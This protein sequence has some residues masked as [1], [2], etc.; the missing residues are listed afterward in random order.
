M[1]QHESIDSVPPPVPPMAPLQHAQPAPQKLAS[2][3]VSGGHDAHP[4]VFLGLTLGQAALML[5][6]PVILA[7]AAYAFHLRPRYEA[8]ELG[9]RTRPAIKVVNVSDTM[10]ALIKDGATVEEAIAR[11]NARFQKYADA[12]YIVIDNNAVMAAPKQVRLK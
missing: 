11:S 6:F 3:L 8:L 5:S 4:K 2:P 7:S 10:R 9:I 12:G 1:S